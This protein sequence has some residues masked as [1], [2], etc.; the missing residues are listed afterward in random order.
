[1]G[2]PKFEQSERKGGSPELGRQT[3][4]NLPS[5]RVTKKTKDQKRGPEENQKEREKRETSLLEFGIKK[6]MNGLLGAG[7]IISLGEGF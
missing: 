6:L 3:N 1:M 2:S 5:R 4:K 7:N